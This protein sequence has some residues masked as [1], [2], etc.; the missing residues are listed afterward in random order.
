MSLS[1]LLLFKNNNTS[2]T[3]NGYDLS[4]TM[5]IVRPLFLSLPLSIFLLFSLWTLKQLAVTSFFFIEKI[6]IWWT[7]S[8]TIT[9]M[10]PWSIETEYKVPEA[11]DFE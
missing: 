5:Y 7:I 10:W 4:T 8:K 6:K 2:F 11:E 1:T 3:R 9:T